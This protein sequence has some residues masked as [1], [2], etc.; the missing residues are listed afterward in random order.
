MAP[1][2]TLIICTVDVPFKLRLSTTCVPSANQ[3]AA[4]KNSL[5]T[6]G[7][8]CFSRVD[9]TGGCNTQATRDCKAIHHTR[10]AH[11]RNC[12]LDLDDHCLVSGVI[13][14]RQTLDDAPGLDSKLLRYSK[15]GRWPQGSALPVTFATD[16]AFHVAMTSHRLPTVHGSY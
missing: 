3:S 5:A 2:F 1:V 13:D 14:D 11:P 9:S 16:F 10:H 15:P 4:L 8:V 7:S 6:E 12:S